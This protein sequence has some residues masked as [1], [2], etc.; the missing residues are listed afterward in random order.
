MKQIIRKLCKKVEDIIEITKDHIETIM[1]RH[2]RES[3]IKIIAQQP[4][5]R[6]GRIKEKVDV[7]ETPDDALRNS[8]IKRYSA[9]QYSY[10]KCSKH[11]F[12]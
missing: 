12:C 8:I 6:S 7:E 5:K 1:R 10:I 3:K 2:R 11:M 4:V 9:L